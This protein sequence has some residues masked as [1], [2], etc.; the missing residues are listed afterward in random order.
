[1]QIRLGMQEGRNFNSTYKMCFMFPIVASTGIGVGPLV[2]I[3]VGGAVGLIVFLV[4]ACYLCD[5]KK[6]ENWSGDDPE[7]PRNVRL[8]TDV[9]LRIK[10]PDEEKGEGSGNCKSDSG[11]RKSESTSHK[12]DSDSNCGDG[13]SL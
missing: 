3:V 1:M 7:G 5:K 6:H 4:G 12:S 10:G 11:S 13:V 2:G 9:E 8:S